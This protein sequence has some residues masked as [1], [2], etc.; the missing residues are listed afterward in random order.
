MKAI[1]LCGGFAKRLWPITKERPKSLLKIGGKPLLSHLVEKIAAVP[2]VDQVLIST[3]AKFEGQFKDFVQSQAQ[4]Q[5]PLKLVVEP[6]LSEGEKLGALGGIQYVI[7]SENIADDVLLVAGDNLFDFDLNRIVSYWKSVGGPVVAVCDIEN[8]ERAKLYGVVKVENELMVDLKEK[9][10]FP[11]TTLVSTGVYILTKDSLGL[12]KSYLDSGM[13]KDR[14]GNF[15][16]WLLLKVPVHGWAWKGQWF[17]VG[18]KDSLE[19]A[20]EWLGS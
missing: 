6:T 9:P 1:L 7:E 8:R 3:N 10:S 5:K 16:S 12:L 19:K 17:D 15:I 14:L 13:P 2:E 4:A 18:D 20:R 11:D